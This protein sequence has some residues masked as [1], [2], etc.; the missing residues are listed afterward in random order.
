MLKSISTLTPE[1]RIDAMIARPHWVA[2]CQE[3]GAYLLASHGRS[4]GGS[5]TKYFLI[6]PQVNPGKLFERGGDDYDRKVFRAWS[7]G[8]A[9]ETGNKKLEQ[10]LSKR[11]A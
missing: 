1:Q 11:S 4:K 10:V 3:S 2:V 7:L 8:E 5:G 9:I 6:I